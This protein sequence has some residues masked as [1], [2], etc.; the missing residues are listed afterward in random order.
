M[1]LQ[2]VKTYFKEHETVP[3]ILLTFVDKLKRFLWQE[4][5]VHQPSI[6][7]RLIINIKYALGFLSSIDKTLFYLHT[8]IRTSAVMGNLLNESHTIVIL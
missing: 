8:Q 1:S 4:R 7:D 2:I 5:V 6:N 3:I